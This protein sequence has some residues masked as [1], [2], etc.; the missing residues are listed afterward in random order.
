MP[1]SAIT[2]EARA[3][4]LRRELKIRER[5]F[6]LVKLIEEMEI[7]IEYADIQGN[8][9]EGLCYPLDN[10][11]LIVID[12]HHRT[13][14]GQRFTL[15]HELGH[16]LL[17]HSDRSGGWGTSEG[18]P[19]NHQDDEANKFASA[20]LLPKQ[21]FRADMRGKPTTFDGIGALAALYDVSLTASASRFL[22]LTDDYAALVGLQRDPEVSWVVKSRPISE[23]WIQLPPG[24]G[25]LVSRLSVEE[26]AA[27]G[28]VP[29]TAWISNLCKD[30]PIEIHEECRA[31]SA[32]TLIILLT[33]I[34][35]PEDDTGWEDEAADQE[36]EERRQRFSRY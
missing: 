20:L 1:G 33:N 18:A 13:L 12:P 34:P 28:Q 11:E 8:G 30:L 16:I 35:D 26:T 25:T 21:M 22:A 14:Q 23:W 4:E 24:N 17:G 29:A 15:A 27:R 9:Q 2:P 7:R 31:T 6:D 32:N 5:V 3:H 36:R 10:Q 19:G